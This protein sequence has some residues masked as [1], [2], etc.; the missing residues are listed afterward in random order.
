MCRS[1]KAV[2]PAERTRLLAFTRSASLPLA[3]LHNGCQASEGSKGNSCIVGQGTH[4][5]SGPW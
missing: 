1:N 3:R 2:V 4:R 5:G